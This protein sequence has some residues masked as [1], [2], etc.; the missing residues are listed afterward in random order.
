MLVVRDWPLLYD[1]CHWD[2]GGVIILCKANED[3]LGECGRLLRNE[4]G[5]WGVEG[6][7]YLAEL[8]TGVQ[9]KPASLP[10]LSWMSEQAFKSTE[11][12]KCFDN[13]Q[14]PRANHRKSRRDAAL[15]QSEAVHLQKFKLPC[16][17]TWRAYHKIIYTCLE[18][19]CAGMGEASVFSSHAV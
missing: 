1:P 11:G 4:E 15:I 13:S 5:L 3:G 9:S 7:A 10:L 8:G 6:P 2:S 18:K 17:Y 19:R 16:K 14:Q 12:L